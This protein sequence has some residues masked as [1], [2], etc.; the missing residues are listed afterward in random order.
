MS[1]VMRQIRRAKEQAWEQK[2]FDFLMRALG[3]FPS[4]HIDRAPSSIEEFNNS[5]VGGQ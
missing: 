4:A 5:C 2:P 1:T 3:W